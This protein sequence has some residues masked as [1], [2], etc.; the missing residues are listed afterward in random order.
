MLSSLIFAFCLL[1]FAFCLVFGF[2]RGKLRRLRSPI[3]AVP[4]PRRLQARVHGL[5][6]GHSFAGEPLLKRREAFFGVYR[7]A[8]FPSGAAAE[9][10]GEM[11][12]GFGGPLERLGELLV[13][14]TGAE[15]N[16]GPAG[17]LGGGAVALQGF[18]PG[19]GFGAGVAR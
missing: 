8:V 3:E 16:E 17:G 12:A 15:V 14:D 5:D 1:Q 11:D 2:L 18:L 9:Y 19:I 7:Y 10:A 6:V 4:G 13:A